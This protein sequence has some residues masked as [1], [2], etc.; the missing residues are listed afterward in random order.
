MN[1]GLFDIEEPM[2]ARLLQ[3]VCFLVL[4]FLMHLLFLEF[5]IKPAFEMVKTWSD[6]VF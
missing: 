1:L 3:I 4:G 6:S 2:L 5:F